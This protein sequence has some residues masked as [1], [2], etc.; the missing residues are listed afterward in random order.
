MPYIN[1]SHLLRYGVVILIVAI[2]L[3]VMLLLDPWLDMSRTPF[4]LFFGAVMV[5]AWC[6]GL[7]T[8]LLATFLSA[9]LSYYFFLAPQ[10]EMGYDL[11]N[12]LRIGLFASQ[13]LLFSVLCET[14][15][16]TKQHAEVNLQKLKLSEERFRLALSSSDILVFEQDRDLR[17][18]W[19]HHPQS[20]NAPEKILGKSDDEIHS[21]SVAE[22]LTAIKRRTL[23]SGVSS[24]EEVCLTIHGQVCYFDLLVEPIKDQKNNIQGII[25][26][27]LNITERKQVELET[28]RLHRELQQ[29]IQQKDESLALFNAWLTS[30]PLALAFLDTELRYVY[31]NEALAAINGVPQCQHIG[32]TLREVLPEWASQLEPIFQHLMQTREPLLNQ[33]LSGETYP[34][35]VYRYGLINYY[36]VC[37]S[38]GQLLGVGVTA[39][40]IT[41]LKQTEQALRES[42]A[43]FR[44]MF[45]QAPV[46]ITLVALDGQFLQVNPA[47]CEIT[48]YSYDELIQLNYQEITHPDDVEVDLVHTQRVLTK[49]ISGY[50]LEKRYIR[51]DSSIV[52]TNLTASLLWDANEQPKYALGIIEDISERKQAEAA[53]HFLVETSTI[54]AASLDYEIAL[55]NVAQLAVPTLADWCSVDILTADWSIKQIAIAT[56]SLAKRKILEEMGQRYPPS[57]EQQHPFRQSLL[58]GKSIF[59]RQL[60]DSIVRKMAQDEEHLQLLQSLGIRSLMVIPLYSRGKLFGTF[61]LTT[62]E[63]GRHYEQTDLALAEDVA[64]RAATAIDNARLYQETQ[65]A[66]R[67]AEQA[68]NRT[69]RLQKVTAALSEALTQQQV[70]DVLVNQGIAAL[71]AKA[72]SVVL[73]SE[74]G[75]ML[76]VVQA[77]GYPD[78][79]INVWKNFSVNAPVP[80]ANTV[81]T[82]QPIFIQNPAALSTK[83][84]HLADTVK[85]TGS[86]AQASIPLMVEGKAIGALGLSFATVQEFNQEDQGFMLTLGQQCAQAIARA[87]LYEAEQAARSEAETANRIKDEFLAVLSHELRTPLNPILGWAKLLRTRK[88]DEVTTA[89]ALETIER[90]AKIQTQLIEDLL[91]VS[92]ILRGKLNL[93]ICA[94]DLRM[95]IASA[96]ETVHLAAEAKSIQIQTVFSHETLQVMGDSNRIQQIIWNL[97]SNAVKFTPP[98]GRVEVHLEQI[99]F[100]AQIQVIDTGKGI[101]PEFLPHVFEYF[102]QADAKTTRVFGGLGLGLA[103]V[104]HLV[105]LHGGTVQVK[106][107]GEGQ[108]A[109]FTVKL[110]LL[111]SAECP[112]LSAEFSELNVSA[113]DSLLAGVKI[114]LVDDQ[115]DVREFFILALEQ[116]GAV[117]KAVA[118]AHEALEVLSQ[119]KS[120]ILLSDIG[121][122]VMDGYMLLREVRTW[123][124]AQGGQIPAIALTAYAGEIDYNLHSAPETVTKEMIGNMSASF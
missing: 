59:Y 30:S 3:V 87:Q 32:H 12:L 94:V 110:P 4:L 79:V 92:R 78:S 15:K 54:L 55:K 75:T 111:K 25:C 23:D 81:R 73:L 7:K 28:V 86:L 20:V 58:Q 49:E 105:E 38:D 27:A 112:V 61:C 22:K 18:Q 33:E 77:I 99:D 114:L 52:W 35:G 107:H 109:T 102:R 68:V 122:P 108:G 26:A 40:D 41:Q 124:P 85:I 48:G 11:A 36:P 93:N 106:S 44:A 104:H 1:H 9:L 60:P 16:T 66:Q 19:V 120:D 71:G 31:A 47:F 42:E 113:D 123:S 29:A 96:L 57:S 100:D 97:L 72:G 83:Y 51:K 14:L 21:A 63:S 39:I 2:A 46:G 13:G 50:S 84:P 90:N 101:S 119:S 43:K 118:S 8:G 89:R 34:P 62:A 67:A 10:Y 98:G 17:Y 45:D 53:Q 6:G 95:A 5:S 82:G 64:R 117:V 121:M 24:R 69:V 115:A 116:Y 80:I 65:Q 103:I 91:D 70:A 76:N 88:Y 37:L 56:A 74:G